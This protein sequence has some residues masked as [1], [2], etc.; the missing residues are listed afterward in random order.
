MFS[1]NRYSLGPNDK[2]NI[3][4]YPEIANEL[5]VLAKRVLY[6]PDYYKT[7][8][9]ISFLKDHK[10]SIEWLQSNSVVVAFVTSRALRISNTENLFES[11][12]HNKSFQQ[13][14]ENYISD[15]IGRA[16]V[17]DSM[18]AMRRVNQ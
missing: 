4:D 14:F 13:D 7:E 1:S 15:E 9:I 2:F 10:I 12:R 8:I 3:R 16:S 5:K 11:S 18:T 6:L 17:A